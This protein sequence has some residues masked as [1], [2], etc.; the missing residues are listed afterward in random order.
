MSAVP[1]SMP[2][3]P[4]PGTGELAFAPEDFA[5]IAAILEREVGIHLA[6]SK[7]A[8]VY[9]RLARRLRALGLRSFRDYCALV[10]GSAG[11]DERQRM[12]AALT[13]NVTRFF[14]EPHHFEHLRRTALPPLLD[15]ARRGACVR[16]WSA[17][18]S[19]GQEPYSM[20]LTI[21][22]LMPDAAGRDVRVLATDINPEVVAAGR[23]G[24]YG[25]AEL[26]GLPAALKERW[27]LP[28]AGAPG[29]FRVGEDLARLVAFREL[30]LT[31]TWPMRR[32]FDAVFCRNVAIY[33][34]GAVQER[35]WARFAGALAVGGWLYAGHSER[36]TGPAVA[37]LRA[38]GSTVYCREEGPLS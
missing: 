28:A 10:G 4:L 3:Q 27:F 2:A 6:P 8:L 22:E 29:R 17:G 31:A 21:L 14:R 12:V 11:T 24:T 25:A 9:A 20:A 35:L 5:A 38:V 1:R 19:T 37:H 34:G 13:T 30:N 36:V 26:E 23:R 15:A 7:Q 16:L 33:F 32:P 18:C